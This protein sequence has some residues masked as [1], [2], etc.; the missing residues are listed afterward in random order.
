MNDIRRRM[1]HMFFMLLN[2]IAYPLSRLYPRSRKVWV[3]G[4]ADNEFTGNPKYLF[5]WVSESRP[6]IQAV[7]I[8]GNRKTCQ[9]IRENGYRACHRWSLKGILAAVRAKVYFFGH[10]SEDVNLPFSGGATLVNLWHGVGLK[11]VNLGLPQGRTSSVQK[12]ANS[13][14]GYLRHLKYLIRPDYIVTTSDFMQKHFMSQFLAKADQCPKLGYP[15]LDCV[16]VPKLGLASEKI[17]RSLGFKW[18]KS[19]HSDIYIYVPTSRDSGRDFLDAAI[20][21][22]ERLSTALAKRN[23]VLYIKPHPR[24]LVPSNFKNADNIRM[25]PAGIDFQTYLHEFDVLI[26]D[27]SSVLYDYLA[28]GAKGAILYTFDME[29]YLSV[30]RGLLYPFEENTAGARARDFQEL[31]FLLEHG[32]PDNEN[33]RQQIEEIRDKFWGG[34][35]SPASPA[36]VKFVEANLH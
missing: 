20:P 29:E 26:T 23:A 16:V 22:V 5:L 8:S 6:D 31:C 27:Y 10:Y 19:E 11:A 25:W 3:F 15:R 12:F 33:T 17:D 35:P 21:D 18:N 2:L 24:T 14:T 28:T 4:A 34:S 9:A 13:L 1:R 36:V 7:W 32:V 30:D